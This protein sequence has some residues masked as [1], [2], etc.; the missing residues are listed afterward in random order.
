MSHEED[1]CDSSSRFAVASQSDVHTYLQAQTKQN[2]C[3]SASDDETNSLDGNLTSTKTSF[4]SQSCFASISTQKQSLGDDL[5][6][7]KWLHTFKFKDFLNQDPQSSI[8]DRISKLIHD[9]KAYSEKNCQPSFGVLIFLCFHS[10]NKEKDF[11]WELNLKDIY[12]YMDHE[13]KSITNQ[14]GWKNSIKQT[15]LTTPCFIKTKHETQKF[16][17]QWTIDSYYRPLLIKAYK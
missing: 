5:T 17:S 3:L 11:S 2:R 8:D 13:F 15:L 7:L 6:E 12:D 16:R 1:E 4:L 10:K 14:H 9:L